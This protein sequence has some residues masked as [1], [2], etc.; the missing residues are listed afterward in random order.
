MDLN[1]QHFDKDFERFKRLVLAYDGHPIALACA[2][3]RLYRLRRL[4]QFRR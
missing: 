4:D 2:W 3:T 1:P